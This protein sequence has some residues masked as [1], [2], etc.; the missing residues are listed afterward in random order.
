MRPSAPLDCSRESSKGV[1]ATDM[2]TFISAL[3]VLLLLVGL[4]TL[5]PA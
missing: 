1:S 2:R 4:A 3:F 5:M